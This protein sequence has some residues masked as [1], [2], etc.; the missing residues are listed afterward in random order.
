[1]VYLA[2]LR[3]VAL[4]STKNDFLTCELCSVAMNYLL[5]QVA[6]EHT[7]AKIEEAIATLCDGLP[8]GKAEVNNICR[9]VVILM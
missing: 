8:Y 3:K 4:K 1:M 9:L 2:S 5:Q 6:G 7:V